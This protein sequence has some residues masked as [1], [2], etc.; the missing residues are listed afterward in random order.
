MH[1]H[2][3]FYSK[4]SE[5]ALYSDSS[6]GKTKADD[7]VAPGNVQEYIWVVTK[8]G[9]PAEGDPNCLT[10][11]YH[12]H[13]IPTKDIDS[14][15]VGEHLMIKLNMLS[16]TSSSN[17]SIK[18]PFKISHILTENHRSVTQDRKIFNSHKE[19][20]VYH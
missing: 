6:Y 20:P 12:S 11:L 15:P 13:I 3:V 9:A 17:K 7:S 4:A 2:T 19:I 1:P 5:G 10:W 18:R 14:G 16:L 8:E